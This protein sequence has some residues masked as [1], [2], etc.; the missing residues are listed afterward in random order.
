MNHFNRIF[1][2]VLLAVAALNFQFAVAAT[3]VLAKPELIAKGGGSMFG[4]GSMQLWEVEKIADDIYGFRYTV[5]RSVFI[6]T[7]DGV[8][9]TDPINPEAAV[10]LREQIRAITDQPVKYVAYSHSHWDHISGGQVF[11]DEGATF[12]AQERCA[13]NFR[14][15]PNPDVVMPDVTFKNRYTIELGGK[16]MTLHYF[17]PTHDN[18]LSVMHIQPENV[19]YTV[20]VANPPSGWTMFYNPA[21]SEDRVWNVVRALDDMAS[22]IESEDIDTIIGGHLSSAVHA[23]TGHVTIVRGTVGPSSAVAER[24]DYWR[25]MINGVRAEMAANTPPADIPDK[26]VAEHYLADRVI[27]Y[28]EDKMRILLRRM[29]SYIQTGE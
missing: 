20:D 5:Y 14:E 23:K 7:K 15:S 25:E 24:R 22:L 6:V 9:A 8:I 10:I 28:D 12:V 21:V 13:E 19:L 26:L 18:C 1:W 2:T 29:V 16:S 27:A 4:S 11:K 17:G 3:H